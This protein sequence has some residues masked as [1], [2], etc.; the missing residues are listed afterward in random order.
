[1]PGGVGEHAEQRAEPEDDEAG[2]QRAL[3]AEAV[4][5]GGGGEQQPGEHEAVGVDDPL[6]V[7][8]RWPR[9]HPRSAG[10]CSVGSA[11]LSTVLPTMT[12]ISE[13]HSTASVFQR[14]A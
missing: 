2:L 6:D 9:C 7:G 11:T 4:A 13:A 1:M 14:R 8:V 12:M 3:A 10:F 5:E